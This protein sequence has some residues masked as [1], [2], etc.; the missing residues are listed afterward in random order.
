MEERP[1]K[2]LTLRVAEALPKDVGRGLARLDPDDMKALGAEVGDIVQIQGKRQTVAKLLP[3]YVE[4]RG[5]G[6]VQVDGLTRTNAQVGLAERVTVTK[7]SAR[8]AARLTLSPLS[9]MRPTKGE[10]DTRY[11]ARLIEGLPMLS[12]DRIR[13][14]I[15]GTTAQEFTV[16]ETVPGGPV[17]VQA[18]TLLRVRQPEGPVEASK[19]S[20]EDIGGL[21][22]EIQRVRE[23][24]ELPLKYPEVF[25]RLG[26]GAP[27]GVLLLGPPG[28][29]KTLIARAVANETDARFFAVSGPEVIHKFYGESEAKLRKLFEEA[30]RQAPSII[31]LDEIDAIAPKRETVV[32]EVEKRVVAQLLALM[33]G[34]RGRGQVI[35]IGATNIPNALD[36][37]LRRPG[38]FDREITIGI[39][40][41]KG[42]LEILEIHSRGMP[43]AEDV[44][45]EELSE[46]THGFVGADLEALCREAAMAALRALLPQIE[47]EVGAI[48]FEALMELRINRAHFLEALKEVEPS[49]LRE[50]TIEVPSVRWEAIGGLEQIKKELQ[51]TME[52]PLKYAP[53]FKHAGAMP[54][55]GILLYGRPGTGKTLLAKAAATESQA[56]F[57]SVKG[58]QLM[59]KWVGESEKGVRE[60]FKR[61][62]QAAPCLIF[63]DEIDAIAPMRGSGGDSHVTERVISQLLTE[64][65]GI[66]ELRGVVVL[67]ATNRLDMVDPALLRP[68]RFDLLIELPLPDEAAR[69]EIL[70]VHTRGKPLAPDVDLAAL[71]R[72]SE[73]RSGADI[74]AICRRATMF[75]IE[76]YLEAHPWESD[77]GFRNYALKMAHLEEALKALAKGGA[78]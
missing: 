43:L 50:I 6:I 11:L 1:P 47:F 37:A 44:N 27:K 62:K 5:K 46:I 48:P 72:Q 24:I 3:A 16:L 58:P 33:D 78:R 22:R 28:C 15:L 9:P 18:A 71:A 23:M 36:P 68:G 32:G 60:V 66:E 26:I 64:L 38:R 53:L 13:A 52:W 8:P 69:L 12:G 76:E 25:E 10:R 67:A 70:R 61:A 7:V 49:A 17:I 56:N 29:G 54:P 41:K 55:K 65:D 77:P 59:S 14:T 75:A 73:G 4:A 30:E 42:R 39:P 20:Y 40:D 45:L 2:T 19:V 51:Q 21:R 74:E 34:L 57:I 63:F 35:I 31:F